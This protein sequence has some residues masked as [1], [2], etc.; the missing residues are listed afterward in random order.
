MGIPPREGFGNVTI[1]VLDKN[2]NE[3]FFERSL[4]ETEVDE[5]ARVGSAVISVSAMDPDDEAT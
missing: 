5:T 2:D 4:Y 3:P 1:K